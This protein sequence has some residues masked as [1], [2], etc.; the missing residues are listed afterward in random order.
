MDAQKVLNLMVTGCCLAAI[1]TT[2][3]LAGVV[4]CMKLTNKALEEHDLI[5]EGM[6]FKASPLIMKGT[7]VSVKKISEES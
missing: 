6:S 7:K 2:G 1:Y 3:K 5:V 4:D